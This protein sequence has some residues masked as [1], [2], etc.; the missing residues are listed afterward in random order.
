MGTHP[1]FESDFDCLTETKMEVK[2]DIERRLETE[3]TIRLGENF[4][5][6]QLPKLGDEDHQDESMCFWEPSKMDSEDYLQTATKL[7]WPQY[8]ALTLLSSVGYD[9][10]K[11]VKYLNEFEF[12][13]IDQR[14]TSEDKLVFQSV[15]SLF[16]KNFEKIRC[17]LPGKSMKELVEYYYHLKSRKQIIN[18]GYKEEKTL[19]ANTDSQ[20]KR[21]AEKINHYENVYDIGELQKDIEKTCKTIKL[22]NHELLKIERLEREIVQNHI[23]IQ[24][25]KTSC[26]RLR[27]TGKREMDEMRNLANIGQQKQIFRW[28]DQEI[29]Y[30][31][32][33][34]KEYG[35]DYNMISRIIQTKQPSQLEKFYNEN[36]EKF[37]L[38]AAYQEYLNNQKEDS[39]IEEI[40]NNFEIETIE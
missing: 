36:C 24:T 5:V 15:F 39:D 38:N 2:T 17:W 22:D 34:L 27:D 6:A 26:A 10:E 3:G 9:T 4:Q 33:A 32:M 20:L 13:T 7:H 21:C 8:A 18:P 35:K 37:L 14:W 28:E 16:G 25:L 29:Y 19:A 31:S 30:F 23:D 12:E 11:A 1:I 40:D